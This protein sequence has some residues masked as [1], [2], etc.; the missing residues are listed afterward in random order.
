MEVNLKVIKERKKITKWRVGSIEDWRKYNKL[1]K[2]HTQAKIPQNQEELQEIIETSLKQTIGQVTI[3]LNGSKPKE[4]EKIKKLRQNRRETKKVYNDAIKIN[5]NEIPKA[6]ENYVNAQKVLREELMEHNKQ[7]IKD[8]LDKL[9]KESQNTMQSIW[10]LRSEIEKDKQKEMYDTITETG[11][12]LI[13]PD[14]TKNYIAE[15]FEEL[16]QARP[17]KPEYTESTQSIQDEVN[18]IEMYLE[19]EPHIE[20]ISMEK[21][22]KSIK[23]LKRNKATGPDELPNEIFI[24]ADEGTRI[25]YLEAMN[26]INKERSIPDIWQQGEICRLYKGKGTKGKCSNERGITLSSNFGKL[27][28]RII[29]ERIMTMINMTEAQAGGRKGSAT[30]DHILIAKELIAAAKR[31][32]KN[33]HIA[34]LDVTK[35][36]DKAWLTGIMHVLHKHGVKDNHWTIIKRLNE[37][38]SAKLQT[39]FGL[40]REIRIKDSIRQGGV[41]STTMYGLLMDEVNKEI[42]KENIG[43]QIEGISNRIG[44]LLWVDD[45]Y[46]ITTGASE[47]QKALDITNEVSNK[48]HV[49]NGISKCNTQVI[50]HSRKKETNYPKHSIGEMELSPVDKYKYLG[51]TQNLKKTTTTTSKM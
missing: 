29:N 25:I 35:A 19:H 46:L 24:E 9:S 8:K 16:Y 28:E 17:A 18:E 20:D 6:L 40:T 7:K 50:K 32:N 43:I 26:K 4:S 33:E 2:E 49:E 1:L 31:E 3:S 15:Y 39:K 14:E 21:L 47:L 34:Y 41:L 48:Y 23:K 38:L 44:S 51:L 37:N 22:M 36:Y 30:V 13:N 27:Y 10:K 5:R 11:V 12:E 42:T 45:V